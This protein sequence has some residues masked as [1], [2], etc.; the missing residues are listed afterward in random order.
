MPY[1]QNKYKTS[2]IE[3]QK[4]EVMQNNVASPSSIILANLSFAKT[5][6]QTPAGYLKVKASQIW[7]TSI[8]YYQK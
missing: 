1:T 5:T 4:T 8:K 3:F 2:Q 7:T 6:K